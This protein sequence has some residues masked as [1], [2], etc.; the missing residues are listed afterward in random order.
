VKLY[1]IRK[2]YWDGIASIAKVLVNVFNIAVT[3]AIIKGPDIITIDPAAW[4]K[5]NLGLSTSA[6]GFSQTLNTVLTV[7][8]WLSIV[9]MVIESIKRIY[10]S[11]IKGSHVDIELDPEELDKL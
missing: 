8:L 7:I 2:G 6:E 1:L 4:Q 10:D 9:G 3:Y 5:I 11:F